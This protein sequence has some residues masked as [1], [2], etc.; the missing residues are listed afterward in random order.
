M[1][2]ERAIMLLMV[3]GL[4]GSS[5]T[6]RGISTNWSWSRYKKKRRSGVPSALLTNS[7]LKG[8]SILDLK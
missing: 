7:K 1:I 3:V 8:A 4:R 5:E 6:L 2:S